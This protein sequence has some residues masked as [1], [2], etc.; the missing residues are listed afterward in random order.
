MSRSCANPLLPLNT[1]CQAPGTAQRKGDTVNMRQGKRRARGRIWR[2]VLLVVISIGGLLGVASTPAAADPGCAPIVHWCSTTVN[3]SAFFATAL[4]NWCTGGNTGDSTTIRPTCSSGGAMQRTFFLSAGGGHTPFNEDWDAFQVDA[5]W[6]YRVKFVITLGTD[7]TRIC[8]RRGT[9]ALYV[10]GADNAD[11]HTQTQS[12][13]PC[14]C[15]RPRHT[16]AP[17]P[18]AQR[19]RGPV[20]RRARPPCRGSSLVRCGPQASRAVR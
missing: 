15:P 16:E 5:G 4:F 8:H 7:F 1:S 3:D 9:A 12:P 14:L 17:G 18:A 6:C 11:A 20:P 13:T 10:K 19:W 2:A